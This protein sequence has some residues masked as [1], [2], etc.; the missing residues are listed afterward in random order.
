MGVPQPVVHGYFDWEYAQNPGAAFSSFIG[1]EGAEL[2]TTGTEKRRSGGVGRQ[3]RAEKEERRQQRE[4]ERSRWPSEM[5]EI[6]C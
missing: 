6:A 4:R 2:A 3:R 1:G 5:P